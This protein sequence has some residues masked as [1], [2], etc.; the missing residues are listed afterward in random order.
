MIDLWK[1]AVLSM[2]GAAA[3]L[4]HHPHVSTVYRWHLYGIRG[5]KLETVLIGGKRFTSEQALQRFCEATPLAADGSDFPTVPILDVD[6][7]TS[8]K[9]ESLGL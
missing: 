2:K 6:D 3:S 9:L 5:I 4:P 7:A 1:E 8:R